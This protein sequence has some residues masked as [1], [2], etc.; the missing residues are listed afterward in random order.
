MQLSHYK[1]TSKQTTII[2][3]LIFTSTIRTWNTL[4]FNIREVPTFF[5]FQKRLQFK[6]F[7]N[8]PGNRY[9]N[10]LQSRLRNRCNALNSDLYRVNLIPNAICSCGKSDE[11]AKRV[12]LHCNLQLPVQS[13]PMI[14]K[15]VNS[16]SL[17]GEV[18]SMQYYVIKFVS[19]I[20]QVSG[21]RRVLP[22]FS[23][24]KTDRHD[25]TE[26]GVKHHKPNQSYRNLIN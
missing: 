11:A 4:D 10:V 5:T 2:P 6:Y 25:I 7:R 15:V 21:F 14:S 3:K 16:N 1:S 23:T 26:S 18:Y 8:K 20:R 17:H 24:N 13:V 22:A 12:L 19:D 9:C